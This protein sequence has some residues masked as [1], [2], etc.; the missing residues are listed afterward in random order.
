MTHHA[1]RRALT[2]DE[3]EERPC[4]CTHRVTTYV[5]P[6]GQLRRLSDQQPVMVADRWECNCEF[7]EQAIDSALRDECWSREVAAMS[8]NRIWTVRD[9]FG[10]YSSGRLE[11]LVTTAEG[12]RKMHF[13]RE[14]IEAMWQAVRAAHGEW[15]EWM[16]ARAK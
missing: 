10:A 2:P 11:T 15:V 12:K 9:F 1:N 3:A 4:G 5:D 16:K 7:G 6:S 13:S 8:R 14:R